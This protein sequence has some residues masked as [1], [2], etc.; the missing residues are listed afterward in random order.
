MNCL[1]FGMLLALA[2]ARA[3]PCPCIP[4]TLCLPISTA[5]VLSELVFTVT[6]GPIY[7][8]K[9]WRN[10][11]AGVSLFG[12]LLRPEEFLCYADARGVRV[13]YGVSVLASDV[14]DVC[15]CLILLSSIN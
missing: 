11:T 5:S 6:P 10:I 15:S 13:T 8:I 7:T 12:A 9:P 3:V 14:H 4:I 1:L 2:A